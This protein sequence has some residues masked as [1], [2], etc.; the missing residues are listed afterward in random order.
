M[1]ERDD[2]AWAVFALLAHI[3]HMAMQIVT[4]LVGG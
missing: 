3:F 2:G 1:T 4:T